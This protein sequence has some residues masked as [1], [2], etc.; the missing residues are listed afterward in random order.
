MAVGASEAEAFWLDFLRSLAWRGLRG[1]K[2]V[3]SDAHEGLTAA[4]TKVLQATWQRC[5]LHF[6]RIA[7]AH[8]GKTQCRIVSAWVGTAYAQEDAAATHTQWR[9]MADQLRPKIPKLAIVMD[10]AEEDV[11]AYMHFPAAH[12]AK[13]HSTNPIEQLNGE[14]KRRTDVIAIFP[15]EAAA[16]RLIGAILIEQSNEWA[17]QRALHDPGDNRYHQRYCIRQPACPG[18][19]TSQPNSLKSIGPTPR[20]G[21][22][23]PRSNLPTSAR[24]ATGQ[25]HAT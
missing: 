11:L 6:G 1:V 4:V 9:I 7:S 2:S 23:Q 12:R 16:A 14:I 13:L 18:I 20:R 19:L 15:N 17:T 21:H 22:D 24:H 8:A 10:A 3:I 25:M 5:R